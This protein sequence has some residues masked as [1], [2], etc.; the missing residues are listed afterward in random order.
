MINKIILKQ[1]EYRRKK[2]G[3]LKLA[4]ISSFDYAFVI[5]PYQLHKRFHSFYEII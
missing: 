4:L 5:H 3:K 1:I 2:E